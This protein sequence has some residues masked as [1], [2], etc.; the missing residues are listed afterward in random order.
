M[1][2]SKA[3]RNVRA[4]NQRWARIIGIV[5]AVVLAL[6]IVLFS[7]KPSWMVAISILVAGFA[8]TYSRATYRR[9]DRSYSEAI[10]MADALPGMLRFNATMVEA[11]MAGWSPDELPALANVYPPPEL[12]GGIRLHLTARPT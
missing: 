11:L 6:D 9:A 4:S 8:F 1:T 7:V 10:W 2:E 3:L 5:I 12:P